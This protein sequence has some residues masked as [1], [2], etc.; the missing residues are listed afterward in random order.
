MKG[1]GEQ[2]AVVYNLRNARTDFSLTAQQRNAHSRVFN[3]PQFPESGAEEDAR[4]VMSFTQEELGDQMSE[5]QE[6]NLKN[7]LLSSS[8]ND[9]SLDISA[10]KLS[11]LERKEVKAKRYVLDPVWSS[12]SESEHRPKI[13]DS[14]KHHAPK[15]DEAKR[16][17]HPFADRPSPW[18]EWKQTVALGFTTFVQFLIFD[19]LANGLLYYG[20]MA[21]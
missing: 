7:E 6:E 19:L 18:E 1:D 11:G 17:Q 2:V 16:P 20:W 15:F 12:S 5:R 4:N 13:R 9:S 10:I 3:Y 14:K 8:L 21:F